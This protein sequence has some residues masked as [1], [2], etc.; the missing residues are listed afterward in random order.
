MEKKPTLEEELARWHRFSDNAIGNMGA[1]LTLFIA[2][3]SPELKDKVYDA[4]ME[5]TDGKA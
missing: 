5:G 4:I 2:T 3:V 1:L